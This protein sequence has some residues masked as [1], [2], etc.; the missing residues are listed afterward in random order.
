[1]ANVN[2][3]LAS[4]SSGIKRDVEVSYQAYGD[5]QPSMAIRHWIEIPGTHG[6]STSQWTC[7]GYASSRQYAGMIAEVLHRSFGY[8][9]EVWSLR[10]FGNSP[11]PHI[12]DFVPALHTDTVLYEG[13]RKDVT[14]Q[15]IRDFAVKW[16]INHYG[17]HESNYQYVKALQVTFPEHNRVYTCLVQFSQSS[18]QVELQMQN[19][20]GGLSV[21]S[22]R[23]SQAAAESEDEQP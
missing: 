4:L 11:G 22:V 1:M 5:L 17:I 21:F 10:P 20:P 2:D 3:F 8:A 12:L 6:G 23:Y 15:N 18:E 7:D 14:E 16:C 19:A 9:Y 13:E